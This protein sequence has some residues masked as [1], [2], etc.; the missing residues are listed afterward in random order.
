MNHEGPCNR[1]RLLHTNAHAPRCPR[2]TLLQQVF[3]KECNGA[4]ACFGS[5]FFSYSDHVAYALKV[6]DDDLFA[7]GAGSPLILA[8]L[9]HGDRLVCGPV[10]HQERRRQPWQYV[11][12]LRRMGINGWRM[13][14][15][16]HYHRL[17]TST[18]GRSP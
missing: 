15:S 12:R 7:E 3:S 1:L 8:R 18:G 4:L 10:H 17:H 13:S 14:W 6:L 9:L 2:W 5:G 16:I 11:K